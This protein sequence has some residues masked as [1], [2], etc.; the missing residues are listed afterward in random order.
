M[1]RRDKR[2]HIVTLIVPLDQIRSGWREERGEWRVESEDPQ[3]WN[4]APPEEQHE[5]LNRTGLKPGAA[6]SVSQSEKIVR[7]RNIIDNYNG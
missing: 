4:W 1:A 5:R 6:Q 7:P 2:R 3:H